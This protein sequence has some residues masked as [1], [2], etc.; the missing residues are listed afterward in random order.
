MIKYLRNPTIYEAMRWNS[1][2]ADDFYKWFAGAPLSVGYLPPGC[3][4]QQKMICHNPIQV[5]FQLIISIGEGEIILNS[6][7]YLVRGNNGTIEAISEKKFNSS[8]AE[9]KQPD[10]PNKEV[11]K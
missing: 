10:V 1:E 7:D 11:K 2:D 9:L 5:S 4:I 3:T 8:F 6:G